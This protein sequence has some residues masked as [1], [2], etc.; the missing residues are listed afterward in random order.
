MATDKPIQ[1]MTLR[2]LL[3]H[4]EKLVRDLHE[5]LHSGFL[6]RINEF[7]DI[8]RPVRRRSHY[9]TLLAVYNSLRKLLDTHQHVQQVAGE[10]IAHL[11]AIN[12]HANR[13]RV[14]RM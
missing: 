13:E 10:L 3:T 11:D 14:N 12:N 5:L 8:S 2:Q 4:S 9:P 7:R 6:S 1:R